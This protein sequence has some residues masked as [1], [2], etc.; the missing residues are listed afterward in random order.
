MST[1]TSRQPA[2]LLCL[3]CAAVLFNHVI[4]YVFF[5][6]ELQSWPVQ[7]GVP[8]AIGLLLALATQLFPNASDRHMP[9]LVIFAICTICAINIAVEGI[10]LHSYGDN[11]IFLYVLASPDNSP[12][13]RWL[14]GIELLRA[15]NAALWTSGPIA[16]LIPDHL[17]NIT[18]FTSLAGITAI[19]TGTYFLYKRWPGKLALTLPAMSPLWLAFSSGYIEYYPFI[20]CILLGILLWFF[21]GDIRKKNHQHVAILLTVL[22]LVYLGFA[23]ISA[24]ILI[25]YLW[26]VPEK[27]LQ[28]MLTSI[29]TLIVT[30]G[31][32]WKGRL[33]TFFDSLYGHFTDTQRFVLAP[34]Y[35]GLASPDSSIFF[36]RDYALSS[37]HFKELAYMAF[38]GNGFIP[39]LLALTGSIVYVRKSTIGPAR[40]LRN[41]KVLLATCILVWQTYYTIFMIPLL[42]PS[43]DIDLFFSSYLMT[44][45]F[46]GMLWDRILEGQTGWSN[47]RTTVIALTLGNA[48]TL[49][50]ALVVIKIPPY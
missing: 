46:A 26:V 35:E 8:F 13:P 34:Q 31:V 32:F 12:M 27:R 4:G 22:P 37:T 25:C 11:D 6:Y 18:S 41:P 39:I 19:A 3:F 33:S 24:M 36:A 38:W 40:L 28:T 42:G 20:V 2:L 7:L 45:F 1:I 47:G 14:V 44:A 21:D 5:G 16:S 29:A 17:H 15:T 50:L 23:P 9:R 43:R 10:T 30:I 48:I 49:F